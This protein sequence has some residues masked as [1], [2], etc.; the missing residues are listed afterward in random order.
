MSFNYSHTLAPHTLA[1]HTL[2]LAIDNMKLSNDASIPKEIILLIE[3]GGDEIVN[4]RTPNYPGDTPL[5]RLINY[6]CVNKSNNSIV[7]VLNII[8]YLFKNYNVD[9]NMKNYYGITPIEMAKIMIQHIREEE[10]IHNYNI[11]FLIIFLNRYESQKK[12]INNIKI[13][14]LL[15]D[16]HFCEHTY[17]WQGTNIECI[18]DFISLNQIHVEIEK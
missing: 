6:I 14:T 16:N 7:T 4:S 1:P 8:Y 13:A 9:I 17:N 12:E 5:H 3:E 2:H 18:F 10:D 15:L 11:E